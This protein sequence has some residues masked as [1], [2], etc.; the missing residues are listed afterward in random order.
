MAAVFFD[1]SALIRRYHLT[2]PGSGAVRALCHGRR[3]NVLFIARLTSVEMASGLNRKFRE[4]A[5]DAHQLNRLWR[6][7]NSHCRGGYHLVAINDQVYARAQQL[8]FV[9]RLRAADAIQ[10][11]GAL[12]TERLLSGLVTD[13]RF[14][15]ADQAQATSASHEGLKVEMIS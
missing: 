11:A 14:C 10:I 15:T 5:L 12:T 1:T 13:F 9:H 6:L 7:F 2:E 4:G 8:L 3:N